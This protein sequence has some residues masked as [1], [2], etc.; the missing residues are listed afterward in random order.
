MGIVSMSKITAQI[1]DI[2]SVENLN[3]VT[4]VSNDIKLEM[5]SLELNEKIKIG[6]KVLLSVKPTA[7]A[8]GKNF[9]GELS[10][11][12]QIKCKIS[13]LEVGEL[14]CSLQMNFN[15]FTLESI[16]TTASQKRMNLQVND[17]VTALIKSSELAI[18]RILS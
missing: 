17:E 13:S 18:E 7:V 3:I 14:L 10:Y 12:N 9:S 6:T 11:S 4:F 16:I 1:E 8:I 5:M 15:A 2:Q